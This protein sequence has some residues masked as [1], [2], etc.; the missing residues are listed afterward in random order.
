MNPIFNTTNLFSYQQDF[1][2]ASSSSN[3]KIFN[4]IPTNDNYFSIEEIFLIRQ[5]LRECTICTSWTKNKW[6]KHPVTNEDLCKA[7]FNRIKKTSIQTSTISKEC[8][9]CKTLSAT[10]W[11]KDSTKQNHLC[12]KCYNR[13]RS[14]SSIRGELGREC[15]SCQTVSTRL[16]HKN[17]NRKTYICQSCYQAARKSFAKNTVEGR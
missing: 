17:P 3:R 6:Y 7:C 2:C 15:E 1:T 13:A 5:A 11:Y 16:W 12:L 8:I 10:K 4:A 9:S 14:A